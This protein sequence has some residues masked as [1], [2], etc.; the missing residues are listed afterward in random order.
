MPVYITILLDFREILIGPKIV[1]KNLFFLRQICVI[2]VQFERNWTQSER[3]LNA[4]WTQSERNGK[5][6]VLFA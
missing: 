5:I 1:E 2:L 6:H 4:I 3:N